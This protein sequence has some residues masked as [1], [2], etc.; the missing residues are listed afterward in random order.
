M[1]SGMTIGW[2]LSPASILL[3]SSSI[4]LSFS[5]IYLFLSWTASYDIRNLSFNSSI[6]RVYSSVPEVYEVNLD[7][8][9]VEENDLLFVLELLAISWIIC[10]SSGDIKL[11]YDSSNNWMISPVVLAQLIDIYFFSSLE[12]LKSFTCF[13][14]SFYFLH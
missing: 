2:I 8:S 10:I 12:L 9:I 4:I 5:L 7:E 6:L 11:P 3:L 1:T 13:G 14:V